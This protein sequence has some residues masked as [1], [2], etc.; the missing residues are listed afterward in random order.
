[1]KYGDAIKDV[2]PQMIQHLAELFVK[3]AAEG[4]DDDEVSFLAVQCLETV[5]A[6]LEAVEEH[7][8]IMGSLEG[9]LAPIIMK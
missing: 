4:Q 3:F 7:E 5:I 8:D 6:I 2:A 9:V 1:M